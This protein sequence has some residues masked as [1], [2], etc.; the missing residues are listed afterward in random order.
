MSYFNRVSLTPSDTPVTD[1][2]GRMR[3]S[4]IT[5]LFDSKQLYDAQPLR[6][7][8]AAATGTTSTHSTATATTTIGSDGLGNRTRT[9]QTKMRFNYQPGKSLMILTTF[10]FGAT[11]SASV[12]KRVG[13][14]DNNNGIFLEYSANVATLY[15]RTATSGSP[16]DAISAVQSDWNIDKFDGTGP[17]KMTLDF[18][19]VQIMWIDMEWLGVGRV[20]IGFVI[21][22]VLYYAHQFLCS[23]LMTQVYM[24]TPN[25]PVRFQL[26]DNTSGSAQS[27]DC[28][29][30]TVA[31]EGGDDDTGITHSVDRGVSALTFANN[32]SIHPLVSIR[33]KSTHLSLTAL[34]RSVEVLCLDTNPFRWCLLLNPTVAGVDAASWTDVTN[35]GIQYDITRSNTNTLTGG[36]VL[37]SGY[38]SQASRD[39]EASITSHLR[40][41]ATAA[42]VRDEIVLGAQ[43][44]TSVASKQFLGA[45]GIVELM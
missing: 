24:S 39:A 36:T 31:S 45:I 30:C 43:L 42:G 33:L 22:G 41:G 6:W 29:C 8:D 27:M 7:D 19:K 28:I 23:N 25:L 17:S 38:S 37:A 2:F 21:N 26:I 44:I 4:G 16:S 11:P 20:R 15:R 5:T 12:K 1:A 3:M 14:F 35:L 10:K 34:I 13:Y 18:T 40:L 32:T 9:R